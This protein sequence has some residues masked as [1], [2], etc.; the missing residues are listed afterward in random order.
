MTD[1]GS[2]NLR[3]RIRAHCLGNHR[4]AALPKIFVSVRPKWRSYLEA[5]PVFKALL[6]LDVRFCLPIILSFRLSLRGKIHF[7]KLL[8]CGN[9]M[10]KQKNSIGPF[11][12]RK[13][14][15]KLLFASNRGQEA[16]ML[17]DKGRCSS[18]GRNPISTIYKFW[19]KE[20]VKRKNE[21]TFGIKSSSRIVGHID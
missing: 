19:V 14:D 16:V 8:N 4:P 13:P 2:M 21:L 10:A 12:D 5:S 18:F 3:T 9:V 20:Y 1:S 6:L 11:L 15:T 17:R 7:Y